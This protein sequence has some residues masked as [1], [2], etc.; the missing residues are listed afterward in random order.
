MLEVGVTAQGQLSFAEARAH[1]GA[2]CVVS[3]PLVLSL[4]FRDEPTVNAMWPIISNEVCAKHPGSI[5]MI[6]GFIVLGLGYVGYSWDDVHVLD[7]VS[8]GAKYR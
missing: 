5:M 7:R 1:F 4:D 8:L 3:S 6:P 2:W